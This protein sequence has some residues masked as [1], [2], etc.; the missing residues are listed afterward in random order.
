MRR[1]SAAEHLRNERIILVICTVLA[2]VGAIFTASV[3]FSAIASAIDL[4]D[5]T[6]TVMSSFALCAGCF[7]AGAAAA[8]RRGRNGIKT[9]L[10]CGGIIFL[11]TLIFGLIF[12]KSFSVGGF[13]TKI[14]I[15]FICSALGGIFGVNSPQRFR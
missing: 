10:A 11:F 8:K 15:I 9:G 13:F 4:S 5:G 12:V 14:L 3:L 1:K 6:F 2:F 7:S